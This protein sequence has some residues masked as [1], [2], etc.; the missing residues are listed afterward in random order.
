MTMSF[1]PARVGSA[2][3]VLAIAL[4]SAF[5][6][7]CGAADEEEAAVSIGTDL[8]T[9]W[10]HLAKEWERFDVAGTRRVR[11]GAGNRWVERDLGGRGFCT[12]DFFG[13]DPARNVFK[14]CQVRI[15]QA[16]PPVV[17]EPKAPAEPPNV[18]PKDLWLRPFPKGPWQQPLP[19]SAIY[20]TPNDARSLAVRSATWGINA[21]RFTQWVW[22][23][24]ADDPIVT[25]DVS[26]SYIG[27]NGSPRA[28]KVTIRMPKEAHPDPGIWTAPGSNANPWQY[29]PQGKDAHL[30]IID[31]DGLHAHEFWHAER[32]PDGQLI[33]VSY[34]KMPLDGDGPRVGKGIFVTGESVARPAPF[35]VGVYQNPEYTSFGWGA[36]R[37]FGG[38]SLG[39]LIR[40]GE[41]T[42]G[43]LDHAIYLALPK[44]I[45]AQAKD[46]PNVRYEPWPASRADTAGLNAVQIFMGSR[47]ALPPGLDPKSLGLGAAGLRLA[48]AAQK[49]GFIVG[50]QSSVATINTDGVAAQPDADALEASGD[51]LKIARQLVHVTVP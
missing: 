35:G 27:D 11:F 37:A 20:A 2:F 12:N 10:T 13:S 51:L 34:V 38:S 28:G 36:C 23:A 50:D 5:T 19:A 26:A 18:A 42:T 24:D 25:F 3:A 45:L 17:L 47:F 31:P 9:G 43:S 16:A 49:Y 6:P 33:A 40:Q 22:K 4:T 48:T 39:G 21:R 15:E 29:G 1:T 46:F 14:T 41:L 32:R 30:T 8:A 7:A 44:E